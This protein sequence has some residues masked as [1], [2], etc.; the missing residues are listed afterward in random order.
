M[1]VNFRNNK[2][3]AT[4]RFAIDSEECLIQRAPLSRASVVCAGPQPGRILEEERIR[5]VI[6]SGAS[7]ERANSSNRVRNS[8]REAGVTSIKGVVDGTGIS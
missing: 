3:P 5:N 8:S 4:R 7:P 1:I 2:I 6:A